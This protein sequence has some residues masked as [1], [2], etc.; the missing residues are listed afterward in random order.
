MNGKPNTEVKRTQ[1]GSRMTILLFFSC[2]PRLIAPRHA[3]G[4]GMFRVSALVPSLRQFLESSERLREHRDPARI[5]FDTSEALFIGF[6]KNNGPATKR[7]GQQIDLLFIL[8]KSSRPFLACGKGIKSFNLEFAKRDFADSSM[9]VL[10]SAAKP[11]KPDSLKGNACP[12]SA[13]PFS[14]RA[15]TTATAPN[16]R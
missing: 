6:G 1:R 15:N 16:F 7:A 2:A 14:V 12:S 4:E 11:C 8:H 10:K 5:A 3:N 13:F 9:M